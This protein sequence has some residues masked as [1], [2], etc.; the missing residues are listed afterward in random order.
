MTS[1]T[2]SQITSE[3][4][5]EE[6]IAASVPSSIPLMPTKNLNQGTATVTQNS[7]HGDT[8][9][10]TNIN[11]TN[12]NFQNM[13]TLN[14]AALKVESR[15][16][17]WQDLIL[18]AW[19]HFLRPLILN[20]DYKLLEVL[21]KQEVAFYKVWSLYVSELVSF[22]TGPEEDSDLKKNYFPPVESFPATQTRNVIKE[23]FDK[24]PGNLSSEGY[25]ETEFSKKMYVE[26]LLFFK[27]VLGNKN[28]LKKSMSFEITQTQIQALQDP[29]FKME[30]IVV[31]I[32]S[33]LV[34][35]SSGEWLCECVIRGKTAWHVH[36]PQILVTIK[37]ILKD[38]YPTNVD[39]N[40]DT[41]TKSVNSKTNDNDD[42]DR[43][44]GDDDGGFW[45]MIL[46]A[47]FRLLSMQA[48]QNSP[49]IAANA[50]VVLAATSPLI[51]PALGCEKYECGSLAN[52]IAEKER[53]SSENKDNFL[54]TLLKSLRD[55]LPDSDPSLNNSQTPHL[56]SPNC[57][58]FQN[59][60]ADD[61]TL[62]S[63][64]RVVRRI[65]ETAFL[66]W[67]GDDLT[68]TDFN[69][70]SQE[71]GSASQ[72]NSLTETP[73]LNV[74]LVESESTDF[75]PLNVREKASEFKS[76]NADDSSCIT[77]RVQTPTP[78]TGKSQNETPFHGTEER[79]TN[80]SS[81]TSVAPSLLNQP[82]KFT[83]ALYPI[84]EEIA[85]LIE[86]NPSSGGV[87]KL[88]DRAVLTVYSEENSCLEGL[89][90]SQNLTTDASVLCSLDGASC[91]KVRFLKWGKDASRF[92]D[93][94]KKL[95]LLRAC[96]QKPNQL[97]QNAVSKQNSNVSSASVTQTTVTQGTSNVAPPPLRL[98]IIILVNVSNY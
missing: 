78:R 34:S 60:H 59:C 29:K 68:L 1:A 32:L 98:Q 76:Q 17:F 20:S 5:S 26:A 43:N 72:D 9:L 97:S 52:L 12:L 75:T 14:S 27:T 18:R 70:S 4:Q 96:G 8:K 94:F 89:T 90:S 95:R 38:L 73:T 49:N 11:V 6:A 39:N 84:Y 7:K 63:L 44:P 82:F 30:P 22:L 55:V 87:W 24:E 23:M 67:E 83:E 15:H 92:L 51:L 46:Q 42:I 48:I 25:S 13:T 56:T 3:T 41:I 21:G 88:S 79:N 81:I 85:A 62:V 64:I 50:A 19:S 80:S 40:N 36:L 77:E 37:Q 16:Q 2:K 54:D 28:E 65:L 35:M 58:L 93:D 10:N 69:G 33:L 31:L 66:K 74:D 91:E 53:D 47:I 57:S 61:Q 45:Q 71:V 86:A